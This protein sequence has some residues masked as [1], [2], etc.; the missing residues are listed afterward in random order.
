MGVT[1]DTKYNR[2]QFKWFTG[3]FEK[4]CDVFKSKETET[5]KYDFVHFSRV[6]Y[7][8]DS[9]KAF[10]RTWNH[11][12]AKNGI[13]CAIGENE[14]GFWP[15]MMKFLANHKMEHEM[16]K[17]SGPNSTN[18]FLPGWIKQAYDKNWKYG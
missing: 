3:T 15:M 13:M 10:D 2:I 16:F 18:Y 5:N 14:K 4:F 6:F 11:L 12:L 7:H 9:A 8:T 1:K 17:C